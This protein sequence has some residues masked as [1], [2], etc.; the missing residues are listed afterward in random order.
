[1][2]EA[3]S[4]QFVLSLKSWAF[5]EIVNVLL[6]ETHTLNSQLYPILFRL[7]YRE[8]IKW[9]SPW[10][11]VEEASMIKFPL[12]ILLTNDLVMTKR[13]VIHYTTI[14]MQRDQQF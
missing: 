13:E 1:M 3:V 5:I 10:V 9:G 6:H 8:K 11:A 14:K 4:W 2:V 7:N 12:Y